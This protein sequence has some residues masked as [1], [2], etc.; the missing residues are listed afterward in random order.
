MKRLIAGPGN[1]FICDE[2]ARL[3]QQIVT[4][5]HAPVAP[6]PASPLFVADEIEKLASLLERGILTQEEFDA[7]KRQLLGL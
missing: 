3:C 6:E 5:E 1:V 7:K 4:E 2:C